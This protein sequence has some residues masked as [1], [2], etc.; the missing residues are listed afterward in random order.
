[1]KEN[2]SRYLAKVGDVAVS[3]DETVIL[4]LI[5]N[6]TASALSYSNQNKRLSLR[7]R[8]AGCSSEAKNLTKKI[9][10]LVHNDA[11]EA[12]DL[13][14]EQLVELDHEACSRLSISGSRSASD[15]SETIPDSD[16]NA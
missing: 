6:I 1:M 11:P 8:E 9:S 4:E 13:L 16:S 3:T 2:L 14:N 15:F 7:K 10:N 5:T 12:V